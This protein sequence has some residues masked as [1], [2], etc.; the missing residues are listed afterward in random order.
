MTVFRLTMPFF[1]RRPPASP[2]RSKAVRPACGQR[3]HRQQ[4]PAPVW[5]VVLPRAARC[6]ARRGETE[7]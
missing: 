2:T 3:V 7:R 6:M 1:R 5:L 4:W